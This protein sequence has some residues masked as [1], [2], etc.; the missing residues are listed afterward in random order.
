MSVN[1]GD[2]T[3]NSIARVEVRPL[4]FWIG[5]GAFAGLTVLGA[6]IAVFLPWTPVPG[7]LQPLAVLMAGLFLGPRGGAA[8]QI[9]YLTLGLSG[10]PVFALPGAGPAYFAGP[11]AGYLF[12]FAP[13]AWVAGRLV[14]GSAH[15]GLFRC[16]AAAV[17]G[18]V[19]LHLSGATWLSFLSGDP[20]SAFRASFLPF[21]LF[22]LSKAALAAALRSAWGRVRR[23]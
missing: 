2:R 16:L 17:A 4:L 9:L 6:K 15:P 3:V 22:D 20:L 10:L 5:V 1:L 13:A 21:V 11:T 19:V 7:T 18:A 23:A 12:G 8:S 14:Q